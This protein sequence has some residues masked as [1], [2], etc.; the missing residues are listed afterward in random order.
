[1]GSTRIEQAIDDIEPA[2][3]EF[4]PSCDD[5]RLAWL[6]NELAAG[7]SGGNDFDSLWSDR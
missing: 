6:A 1:M 2:S 4:E 7:S 3:D 5:I